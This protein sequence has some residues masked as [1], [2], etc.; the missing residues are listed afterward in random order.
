MAISDDETP[1][2]IA[3]AISQGDKNAEAVLYRKYYKATLFIVE[4][5]SGD[6]ELAQ[7]LCQEAFCI[8]LERLRSRPLDDPDKLPAFL[9]SIAINLHI[10]EIRK[11]GRRKTFTDQ[12]LLDTVADATQNQY[13]TLLR[14]RQSGA[15][16]RVIAG[17]DN[18]RDRK[19]LYAFYIL[20]KDKA[21]ICAELDLSLRHFDKVL[22]RAKQRFRDLVTSASSAV[23]AG[24]VKTAERL[25]P[26]PYAGGK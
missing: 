17:M 23:A 15:V 16:R 5:K 25:K 21:E 20:E 19:L 12:A 18:S 2:H 6:R 22:F 24:T 4:R 11:A 26:P 8:A 3:T 9:H 13:R 1:A 14:E 10:A 7:D